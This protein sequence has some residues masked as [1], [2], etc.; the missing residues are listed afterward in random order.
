MVGNKP[1]MLMFKMLFIFALSFDM[2]YS[3]EITFSRNLVE[4][5]SHKDWVAYK[6]DSGHCRPTTEFL[7]GGT[8]ASLAIL[9]RNSSNRSAHTWIHLYGEYINSLVE[10]RLDGESIRWRDLEEKAIEKLA[11]SQNLSVTASLYTELPPQVLTQDIVQIPTTE[12]EAKIS[13]AGSSA[14]L[15]FCNFID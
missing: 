11:N 8:V 12:H 4:R 14:S 9:R 2:A 7:I 13:L 1:M 10:L 15:R 6:T 3:D 5:F